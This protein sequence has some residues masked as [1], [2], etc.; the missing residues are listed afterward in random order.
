M[1][2]TIFLA[3]RTNT[4]RINKGSP[5]YFSGPNMAN[6]S[7]LKCVFLSNSAPLFAV[8]IQPIKSRDLLLNFVILHKRCDIILRGT[9]R[10][11]SMFHHSRKRSFQSPWTP[12]LIIKYPTFSSSVVTD[13]EHSQNFHATR[14]IATADLIPSSLCYLRSKA[15]EVD[16]Y[17]P[18]Y[19]ILRPYETE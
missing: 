15:G 9:S 19:R 7:R 6:L 11:G 14:P 12:P 13:G 8:V 1:F 10:V 5:R 17:I 3:Q 2:D 16:P 4:V 18:I